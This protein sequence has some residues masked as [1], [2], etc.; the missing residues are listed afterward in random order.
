[1][2]NEMLYL[3]RCNF[4]IFT[5]IALSIEYFF[6]CGIDLRHIITSIRFLRF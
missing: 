2:G 3:V 1:M 6:E 5:N 4:L